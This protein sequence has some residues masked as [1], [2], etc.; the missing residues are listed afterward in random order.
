AEAHAPTVSLKLAMRERLGNAL[1]GDFRIARI[2][3]H[4]YELSPCVRA[5]HAGSARSHADLEHHVALVG[6]GA[7][8][9]FHEGDGFLG[10]VDST[11]TIMAAPLPDYVCWVSIRL[12]F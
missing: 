9:V 8:K 1:T 7:D 3:V 4:T 10:G 12:S 11:I 2:H 5:G 6:V